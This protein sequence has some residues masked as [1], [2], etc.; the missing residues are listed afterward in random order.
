MPGA[1]WIKYIEIERLCHYFLDDLSEGSP[2]VDVFLYMRECVAD[3]SGLRGLLQLL[4][5]R[6]I[7]HNLSQNQ[8][9][10]IRG[11]DTQVPAGV[12]GYRKAVEDPPEWRRQACASFMRPA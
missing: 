10:H 4:D 12:C 2:A 6:Q 11:G 1:S 9:M 7:Y 5:I 3:C 8:V